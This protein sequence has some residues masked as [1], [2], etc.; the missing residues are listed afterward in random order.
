MAAALFRTRYF[1]RAIAH[2]LSARAISHALLYTRCPH[3]LFHTRY[4]TRA[5]RTCVPH[6]ELSLTL[7]HFYS[8]LFLLNEVVTSVTDYES[9]AALAAAA[10][11][12]GQHPAVAD[13]ASSC[14]YA[15]FAAEGG[16]LSL[17]RLA[18]GGRLIKVLGHAE[19]VEQAR[20]MEHAWWRPAFEEAD[21]IL[22][23][24]G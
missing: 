14:S 1:T 19:M 7:Q 21:L 24:I 9:W 23:S 18:G 10:A 20:Q 22:F 6:T 3:A 8:F 17:A 13:A 11:E 5:V 2:A 15:G 12:A 16:P 4:C